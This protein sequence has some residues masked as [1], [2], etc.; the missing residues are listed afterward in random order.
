MAQ[1]HPITCDGPGPHQP[2]DGVIGWAT[3]AGI[4]QRCSAPPCQPTEPPAASNLRA[5]AQ[6]APDA[7]AANA[8]FLARAT[9]TNAQ[10]LD[11]VRLLTREVNAL[12][13][14]VWALLDNIDDT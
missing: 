8:T 4:H 13:R 2:P 3:V 5:L 9:P 11:Q 7:V 12:V 14:V 6:R 1:D 10:V